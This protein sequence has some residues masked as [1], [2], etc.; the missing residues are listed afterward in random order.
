[1]PFRPGISG[2]PAGRPRKHHTLTDHIEEKLDKPAFAQRL[3]DIAMGRIDGTPPLVQASC[4]REI[5][6]RIDGLC[7]RR[8]EVDSRLTVEVCYVDESSR[9]QQAPI[10]VEP[11]RQI[12]SATLD[13]RH[14]PAESGE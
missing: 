12:E 4:M 6:N 14:R 2:N 5:L 10:E 9:Y 1:M 13:P 8:A 7:V 3:V 11:V